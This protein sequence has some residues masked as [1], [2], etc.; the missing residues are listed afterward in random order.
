MFRVAKIY[1]KNR[2]LMVSCESIYFY[3]LVDNRSTPGGCFEALFLERYWLMFSS[4]QILV[5]QH[6]FLFLSTNWQFLRVE[7]GETYL[8][9]EQEGVGFGL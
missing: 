3:R 2:Y 6:R 7:S 1:R 5:I 4:P 8:G 9:G